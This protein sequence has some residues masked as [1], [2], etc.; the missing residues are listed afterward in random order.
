MV[1]D[2]VIDSNSYRFNPSVDRT[3]INGTIVKSDLY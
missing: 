1:I 3:L 2:E